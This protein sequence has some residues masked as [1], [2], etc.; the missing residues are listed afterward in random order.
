MFI[1]QPVL[2]SSLFSSKLGHKTRSH[3]SFLLLPV[4][5]GMW[6]H[7]GLLTPPSLE[8]NHSPLPAITKQLRSSLGSRWTA[9]LGVVTQRQCPPLGIST[10]DHAAQLVPWTHMTGYNLQ[11]EPSM[12]YLSQQW[13]PQPP[14]LPWR[15]M[16]RMLGVSAAATP[17][18]LSRICPPVQSWAQPAVASSAP[19]TLPT[20]VPS[21]PHTTP[22]RTTPPHTT[23][24]HTITSILPPKTKPPPKSAPL[25]L[26]P[27]VIR[28]IPSS[29]SPLCFIPHVPPPS[30][31]PIH[32][33]LLQTTRAPCLLRMSG[34]RH[35]TLD[36]SQSCGH[37]SGMNQTCT[38]WK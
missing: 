11:R 13:L 24:P 5:L 21:P 30:H 32:W 9:G 16:A 20:A 3:H 2:P 34:W 36:A 15:V 22:P 8:A 19:H 4:C 12:C 1:C 37:P 7:R 28:L 29:T 26:S 35:T 6:L 10:S 38:E 27:S 14:W 25:P 17:V 23:P 18:A 31:P 33:W